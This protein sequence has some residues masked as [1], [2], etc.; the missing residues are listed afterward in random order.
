MKNYFKKLYFIKPLQEWLRSRVVLSSY[1]MLISLYLSA[2]INCSFMTLSITQTSSCCYRLSALVKADCFKN[3]SL[4]FNSGGNFVPT[5]V[6]NPIFGT[7]ISN[8]ST[9]LS[10]SPANGAWFPVNPNVPFIVCD[11]C[12]SNPGVSVTP[13]SLTFDNNC[14]M[15]GC[16]VTLNLD[17][18]NSSNTCEKISSKCHSRSINIGTGITANGSILA[19][20]QADPHWTLISQPSTSSL[21][22]P[23]APIVLTPFAGWTN[24]LSNANWISP[25]ISS[26]YNVNNCQANNCSCPPFVYER[27]FCVCDTGTVNFNFKFASDN[28]GEVWLMPNNIQLHSNCSTSNSTSN[29]VSP[30]NINKNIFL[31]AAGEYC[32]EIRHW[33]NSQ[34]AMGVILDGKLT[35]S[36]LVSDECCDTTGSVMVVKYFD[37]NCDGRF[38]A[39]TESYLQGWTFTLNPGNHVG[40]SSNTGQVF[41]NNIASGTYILTESPQPG[42]F[43]S[44]PS[45]GSTSVIVTSNNVSTIFFGN[46]KDTCKCNPKGGFQSMMHRPGAGPNINVSCNDTIKSPCNNNFIPWTLSGVFNCF[47]DNCNAKPFSAILTKPDGQLSIVSSNYNP[48]NFTI[49][50]PSNQFNSTGFYTL[51]LTALCGKD[52]CKCEIIICVEGC[53]IEDF[54]DNSIAPWQV[55]NG[56]LQLID[57]PTHPSKELCASDSPGASWIYNNS[58][59][60]SGDLFSKINGCLCF[61]IR[62]I[63][64]HANNSPTIPTA[65]SVYSVSGPLANP[66][67]VFIVTAPF[68]G[69]TWRKICIPFVKAT[70]S[71]LPASADGSWSIIGGTGNSMNDFNNLLS[72]ASGIAIPVDGGSEQTERVYVDNFCVEKCKKCGCKGVVW[73]EL[74]NTQQGLPL[75]ISCNNSKPIEI[76]CEKYGPNFFIHGDL[77]C[78]STYCGNDSVY[79]TLTKPG[80]GT[81]NGSVF[82]LGAYPHFDISIPWNE[83]SVPGSYSLTI[84][85]LCNGEPCCCTF[86]INVIDCDC[87]CKE[88]EKDINVGFNTTGGNCTKCF[89]PIG[90]SPCD[91]QVNWFINSGSTYTPIGQSNGN[92]QFCHTFSNF[93][94]YTICMI[95]TR[96]D[97]K[98]LE[99][100]QDT[101]CKRIKVNC[102][103]P[104]PD[105]C[106]K[107]LISNGNFDQNTKSGILEESGNALPWNLVPGS[108]GRV[109]VD[110]MG[111]AQ[112]EGSVILNS[113]SGNISIWQPLSEVVIK[114]KIHLELEYINYGNTASTLEVRLQKEYYITSPEDLLI[115]SININLTKAWQ[116]LDLNLNITANNSWKYL[117]LVV[118][119]NKSGELSSIGIDN[120]SICQDGNFG[121]GVTNNF[122]E[123]TD[124]FVIYPNPTTGDLNLQW[125]SSFGQID[126]VNLIDITGKNVVTKFIDKYANPIQ[127]NVSSYPSGIYFVELVSEGRTM[128]TKKLIKN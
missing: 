82:Q 58:Q 15:E 14:A 102:I 98:T 52:T 80:V 87:S 51:T 123:K 57:D 72:S 30:Q 117:V 24:S 20:G 64:G 1:L 19:P 33:N 3:L 28:A 26:S 86:N 44:T 90:L 93:G 116:A 43:P 114:N 111:G 74:Y 122:G 75:I 45:G 124:G 7:V 49:S 5:P 2:Q 10:I 83:F 41:F 101:F 73:A 120:V 6:V 37:K 115:S 39:I 67:A 42:W 77:E 107:N 50:I 13:L 34:V 118:K 35:G 103:V 78:T 105:H 68:I 106:E 21:G 100:C 89:T 65:L 53:C 128:A 56:N 9:S 31:N 99:C 55:L 8:T 4:Q 69:N 113:G 18:C 23:M 16:D 63:A 96:I 112:D 94:F 36:N 95:V 47:P 27:C 119:S 60:T 66:R 81:S 70:S 109:F 17:G 79:W 25:F 71:T 84:C 76:G 91:D 121:T 110:N 38:N 85:R 32:L 125:S 108:D 12:F 29:F 22:L 104:V 46:C 127:I 48:P 11:F 92:S 97:P 40:V 54:E 88:L 59:Q 126:K 62:Y 61:D